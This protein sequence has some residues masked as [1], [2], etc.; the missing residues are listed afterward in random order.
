MA[1]Q[2]DNLPELKVHST[3]ST[4]NAELPAS[5]PGSDTHTF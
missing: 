2:K 1:E 3:F 4:E 5:E